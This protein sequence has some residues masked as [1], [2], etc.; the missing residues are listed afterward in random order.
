MSEV[1]V[2]R[3]YAVAMIQVSSDDNV[4]DQ[5]GTDLVDFNN[6]LDA[7][8]GKLRH[9]LC[10]PLFSSDER[11]AVLDALL[12]KLG[13]HGP[14]VNFVKL[15][16]AKGR[17]PAIGKIARA[18]GDLADELAGRVNVRVTTAEPM[19]AQIEAEVKAA[20]EKS[21]GKSVILNADVDSALIGGMVARV[22]GKVYDSSIRTRLES[23][24]LSL[25]NAQA[26]GQA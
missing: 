5:V 12:P 10:T 21:T 4:V 9:T 17:L 22:G 19:S 18:Y 23:I 3:R 15:V 6:L 7:N 2:A 14:S 13:M 8:N 24:K 20:M 16:N 1:S 26:P 25:L 11:T